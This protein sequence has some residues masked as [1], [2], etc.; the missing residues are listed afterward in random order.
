MATS[1]C[2]PKNKPHPTNNAQANKGK[3]TI[4]QYRQQK[5]TTKADNKSRQQKM[6]DKLSD[7]EN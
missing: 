2:Q 1:D 5:Q 4:Q 3:L 7:V 6:G